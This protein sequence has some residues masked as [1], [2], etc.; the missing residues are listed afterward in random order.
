MRPMGANLTSADWNWRRA[1]DDC[2]LEAHA[3]N[4]DLGDADLAQLGRLDRLEELW[5]ADTR[6]TDAGL[7]CLRQ[8]RQLRT[9]VLDHTDVS[10]TFLENLAGLIHL[11][12]LGL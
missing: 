3:L 5:L 2:V 4:R 9:L 1:E 8:A 7:V 12:E 6:V 10:D 11:E